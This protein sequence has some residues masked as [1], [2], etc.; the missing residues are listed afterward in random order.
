MSTGYG[1]NDQKPNVGYDPDSYY[2]GEVVEQAGGTSKDGDL[3][4]SLDV[5]LLGRLLD[6]FNPDGGTIEAPEAVVRTHLK[7]A[8]ANM[9]IT[10]RDLERLGFD[11]SRDPAELLPGEK[12]H[13]S[14]VGRKIYLQAKPS[15]YNGKTNVFW[16][17]RFPARRAPKIDASERESVITRAREKWKQAQSRKAEESTRT[18]EIPF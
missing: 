5:K 1:M 2:L 9:E 8:D 14:L 6:N 3:Q 16:N 17:L 11:Q 7:F 4:V 13:F 15:L 12:N 18:E 10:Q